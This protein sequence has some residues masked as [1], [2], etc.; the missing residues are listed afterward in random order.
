MFLCLREKI[1]IAGRTR[2]FHSRPNASTGFGDLLVGF[3]TRPSFKI[4]DPIS[5]KNQVRVRIN[6]SRENDVSARIDNFRI[7]G[8]PLDRIARS[9]ELYPIVP[10]KHPAIANN[11]ELGHLRTDAR[12]LWT[13]Q[14][15][16]LRSVKN[17]Q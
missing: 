1:D 6:K 3:A 4:I 2:F 14:R 8:L 13:G 9:D 5:C 10:N 16:Q 17:S 7:A 15:D 12:P 11:R